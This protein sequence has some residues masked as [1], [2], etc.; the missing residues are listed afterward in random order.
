MPRVDAEGRWEGN[1]LKSDRNSDHSKVLSERRSTSLWERLSSAGWLGPFG[2]ATAISGAPFVIGYPFMTA[3]IATDTHSAPSTWAIVPG[4]PTAIPIG[5]AA[6]IWTVLVALTFSYAGFAASFAP[7]E[8]ENG[9][10]VGG[11]D[12]PRLWL[13]A[14]TFVVLIAWGVLAFASFHVLK[15]AIPAW[16]ILIPP[17]LGW[18]AGLTTA[19]LRHGRGAAIKGFAL[20]FAVAAL[21]WTVAAFTISQIMNAVAAQHKWN[22]NTSV[23]PWEYLVALLLGSNLA[24][25]HASHRRVNVAVAISFVMVVMVATLDPKD[26]FAA[27]FRMLHIL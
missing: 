3:H 1:P 8:D 15:R 12:K 22:W 13:F 17:V 14:T 5:I 4:V 24:T 6:A 26:F 20:R 11:F 2:I 9:R 10:R 16:T 25:L 7:L 27:P 21:Y 18:V 23:V 19:L